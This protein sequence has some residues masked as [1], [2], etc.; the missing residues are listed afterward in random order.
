MLEQLGEIFS[1]SPANPPAESGRRCS[2]G[3]TGWH[4]VSNRVPNSADM[5]LWS[6]RERRRTWLCQAEKPAN[7]D[8]DAETRPE[9]GGTRAGLID[10]VTRTDVAAVVSGDS[11]DA[12]IGADP[13][14]VAVRGVGQEDV[15]VARDRHITER[16]DPGP[17]GRTA[18]TAVPHTG[19]G[20][21]D[22]AQSSARVDP[23]HRTAVRGEHHESPI[24][25]GRNPGQRRQ[26]HVRRDDSVQ[27]RRSRGGTTCGRKDRAC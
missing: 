25:R 12:A 11:R 18:V 5:T 6:P 26:G 8:L 15:A 16:A 24:W 14:H 17:P 10:T 1:T 27:P 13:A 9:R 22:H 20:T 7:S 3:L 2:G 19:S 23:K 21:Q 4:S